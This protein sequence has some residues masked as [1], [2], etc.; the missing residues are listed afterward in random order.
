MKLKNQIFLPK[1]K[2]ARKLLSL[3]LLMF[4]MTGMAFAQQKT[5]TGKVTDQTGASV[6][7][8]TVMIKGTTIGVITGMDGN[9]SISNVPANATLQFSFVGLKGQEV[10]VGTRNSINITM[11]AELTDLDEVVVVGYGTQKRGNVVGAV[12]SLSLIHISEPTRRTP[13]SYAV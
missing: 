12:A 8:V 13:I 11:E 2:F 4:F 6:P 3:V 5:I 1:G 7:G 10:E 9:Y